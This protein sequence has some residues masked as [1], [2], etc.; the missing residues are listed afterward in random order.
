MP[1]LRNAM[2]GTLAVCGEK[3]RAA[4]GLPALHI[5]PSKHFPQEDQAPAIA[6]KIAE[7]AAMSSAGPGV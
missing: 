1:R 5:V 7:L 4:A 3:A 2:G 6:R